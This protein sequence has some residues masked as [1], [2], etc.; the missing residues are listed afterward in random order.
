MIVILAAPLLA[1]AQ[2]WSIPDG[3]S[4]SAIF[5]GYQ[6]EFVRADALSRWFGTIFSLM[7]F[8]GGLFA[9]NQPHRLELCAAQLYAGGALGVVFAGDLLSVLVFWEVMALASATIVWSAGSGARGAGFRYLM[10]HLF[11]GVVLLIGIVAHVQTTGNVRFEAM[12]LGSPATWLMLAGFL[13]N[14]GAPP[15]PPGCPTPIPRHP[16]AAWSF[17][18][19]LQRRLPSTCCCVAFPAPRS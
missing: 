14:A 5:L 13:L 19:R 12:M 10:M 3:V 17:S 11:G 7:A 6:I 4:M 8:G 9:L 15:C 2:V 18:R 1:L 16:T